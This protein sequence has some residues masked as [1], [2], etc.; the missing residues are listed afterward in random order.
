[1]IRRIALTLLLVSLLA[2]TALAVDRAKGQTVYVPAYSYVYQGMKNRPF[3]LTIILSLRNTDMEKSLRITRVD[4][5]DTEGRLVKGYQD[6]PL[7]LGPLATKEYLINAHDLSGGSG[8]NF[9]VRW[10]ADEPVV[11][12]LIEAVMIGTESSQGISFRATGKVIA[13]E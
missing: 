7:T 13:E 9:I 11:T 8:A 2:G 4:Y 12:P 6:A 10:N 1:M 5:Y 3:G